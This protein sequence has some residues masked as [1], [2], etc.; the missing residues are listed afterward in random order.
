[1]KTIQRLKPKQNGYQKKLKKI[2]LDIKICAIPLTSWYSLA[3][4]FGDHLFLKDGTLESLLYDSRDFFS[5]HN[6]NGFKRKKDILKNATLVKLIGDS[7]D[8]NIQK[9]LGI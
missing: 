5:K 3:I 1:M 9:A 7:T 6:L 2:E 8:E 4:K